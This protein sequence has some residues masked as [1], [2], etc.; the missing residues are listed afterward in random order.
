MKNK[1]ILAFSEAFLPALDQGGI[2]FSAYGLYKELQN[3]GSLLKVITSDRNGENRLNVHTNTWSEYNGIPVFYCKTA[4][5]PYLPSFRLPQTASSAAANVDLIIS[6]GTLWIH[7]GI[8]AHATARKFGLPHA[9]YVH[10]LLDSWALKYK[11]NRKQMFWRIQGRRILNNASLV[12][13]LT[14]NEKDAI[15]SLGITAPIE[16]I[17]NGLDCTTPLE[18]CGRDELDR[19]FPSIAGKR[20]L[21]FMGRCHAK[22]GLGVLIPAFSRIGQSEKDIA[23]VLAGRVESTFKKELQRLVSESGVGNRILCTGTVGGILKNNLLGHASG[24]ILP[25]FSEGLPMAVLEALH[26][27]CPVII[28]EQ[29]NIPEVREVDAGWVIKPEI[30]DTTAA[31]RELLSDEDAASRKAGRGMNLVREKFSW[32]SIAQ[33]TIE[34]FDRHCHKSVRP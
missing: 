7:A 2:P 30:E 11:R 20:Y 34:A 9:V 8:C 14:Q 29:C 28:S 33:R 16:V 12:V 3:Q 24:F 10:G 6:S 27:G 18:I 25:S 19:R 1:R 31:I 26:A 23:F 32:K 5:G 21:I 17:P 15:K 13:A 22:K 4:P